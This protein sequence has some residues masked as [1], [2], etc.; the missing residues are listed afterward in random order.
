LL[1][2]GKRNKDDRLN[3]ASLKMSVDAMSEMQMTLSSPYQSQKTEVIAS[4]IL[5]SDCEIMLREAYD[6]TN[7]YYNWQGLLKGTSA[8]IYE[9]GPDSFAQYPDYQLFTRGYRGSGVLEAVGRRQHTFLASNEWMTIPWSKG[10]DKDPTDIL[11][12]VLAVLAGCLA[13]VDAVTG[14][15]FHEEIIEDPCEMHPK[16]LLKKLFA[17]ADTI[18]IWEADVQTESE[19]LFTIIPT[20]DDDLEPPLFPYVYR[21]PN[22]RLGMLH[23]YAWSSLIL[24]YECIENLQLFMEH[25][26]SSWS[27]GGPS[28]TSI[29][30]PER[31]ESINVKTIREFSRNICQSVDSLLEIALIESWSVVHMLVFPLWIVIQCYRGRSEEESRF[32]TGFLKKLVDN[33]ILFAQTLC[34]MSFEDY[35]KM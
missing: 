17:L 33:D 10:I 34:T 20:S 35:A 2:A 30:E 19:N 12:D 11:F 6:S 26:T 23:M 8:L 25:E 14:R 13:D 7:Q 31:E 21:F 24:I 4:T 29:S 15:M 22:F 9:R 32:L 16:S 3:K 18:A 28:P 27:S 1:A 5:L